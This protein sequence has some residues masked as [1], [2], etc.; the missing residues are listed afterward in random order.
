MAAKSSERRE[1]FEEACGIAKYRYRKTEAERRLAAAGE[2]LERL[3]DI[4]G[5]L[6]S[7]VGPLEKES[8]KAQKFLELSA[9]KKTLEVTL[10]TDGVHRAREAVRQQV[11]DYETAQADY[12]RFDRE[13]KAAEQEAEEI[14]MQAQQLTVA[15]ERLNGDIRSITEQISGSVTGWLAPRAACGIVCIVGIHPD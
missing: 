2:N 3:R 4:L 14:R 12:E 10:W 1:I 11:R 8:A 9:E 15:V 7:R 6:E 13:T 5:E